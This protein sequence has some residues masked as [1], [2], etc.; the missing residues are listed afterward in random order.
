MQTIISHHLLSTAEQFSFFNLYSQKSDEINLW[1]ERN[2]QQQI[3]STHI[4]YTQNKKSK[5]KKKHKQIEN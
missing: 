1:W 4:G 5:R 2:E 3:A